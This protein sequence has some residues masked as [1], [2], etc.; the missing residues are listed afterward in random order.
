MTK[1]EAVFQA[2]NIL[3]EIKDLN[4]F[5]QKKDDIKASEELMKNIYIRKAINV[6]EDTE[7]LSNETRND[8]FSW[9]K[10]NIRLVCREYSEEYKVISEI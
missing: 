4:E 8:L 10:D 9:Y 1:K 2:K 3:N 5:Y 7:Y 6:M